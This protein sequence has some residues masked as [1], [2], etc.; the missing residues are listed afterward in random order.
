MEIVLSPAAEVTLLLENRNYSTYLETTATFHARRICRP[1]Q[2]TYHSGSIALADAQK[3][4][5]GNLS[6]FSS[7]LVRRRA[8]HFRRRRCQWR[9]VESARDNDPRHQ[10]E[11][12]LLLISLLTSHSYLDPTSITTGTLNDSESLEMHCDH[13]SN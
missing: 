9:A 13:V 3:N 12:D 7:R 6:P 11:P 1:A 2:W 5:I 10:S 4:H 8:A